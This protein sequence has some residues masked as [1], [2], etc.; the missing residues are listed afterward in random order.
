MEE[1]I[2]GGS[3]KFTIMSMIARYKYG[4]KDIISISREEY[5]H[6]TD[7]AAQIIELCADMTP[8]KKNK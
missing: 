6:I 5:Q 4:D 3:I 1:K 7:L 8:E 2:T